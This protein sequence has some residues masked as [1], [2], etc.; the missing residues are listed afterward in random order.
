[1]AN[2][3]TTTYKVKG[4]R[5]A[6]NNLWNALD[7]MGANSQRLTLDKLAQHYGIDYKAKGICVRG[8]ISWAELSYA[9]TESD[10]IL[11]FETET[12]WTACDE[13]FNEIGNVLKDELSISFREVECGCGIYRVHDEGEFFPEECCVSACGEPFGEICE[14]PID[15]EGDAIKLWCWLTGVGQGNKSNE[16]MVEL[17]NGYDYGD[18]DTFF[19]IRPFEFV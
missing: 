3:A 18:D 16:E 10:D 2:L 19:Q 11:S 5:E 15:T 12:A 9:E 6:V 4:T 13:L 14:E 1:M 8:E 7:G 17:I